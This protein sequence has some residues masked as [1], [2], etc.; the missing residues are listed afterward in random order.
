MKFT[1]NRQRLTAAVQSAAQ[2]VD[3]TATIELFR[4]A[5]L[6]VSDGGLVVAATDGQVA[7]TS[8]CGQ[9]LESEPG[10]LAV[11][12]KS[13]LN[14]VRSFDGE[15]V[16][17]SGDA[18]NRLTIASADGSA[19]M[20]LPGINGR[21]FTP[22]Y[23][24][25]EES[26]VA[27]DGPKFATAIKRVAWAASG[28]MTRQ[29]LYGIAFNGNRLSA[30]NGH[31]AAWAA[32]PQVK[33]DVPTVVLTKAMLATASLFAESEDDCEIAMT[34]EH[35]SARSNGT[36]ITTRTGVKPP[37]LDQAIP[38]NKLHVTVDHAEMLSAAKRCLGVAQV[39]DKQTLDTVKMAYDEG[40]LRLSLSNPSRGDASTKLATDVPKGNALLHVAAGYLVA[41]IEAIDGDKVVLEI[42]GNLEPFVFRPV[43]DE[44]HFNVLFPRSP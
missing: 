13:L 15:K 32:T 29:N 9:D 37:P 16:V 21:D 20:V 33:V 39:V 10:S 43:N 8:P 1:A 18:N 42:G 25:P 44:T 7:V 26:F 17:L 34:A 11:N 23:E 30:T 28:D 24:A 3:R 38:K 40:S 2:V 19:T 4:C 31:R 41:A 14:A 35:F 5:R 36:E 22:L 6:A 12:A 27:V